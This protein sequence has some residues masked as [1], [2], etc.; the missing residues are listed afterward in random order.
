VAKEAAAQQ[1][2][3]ASREKLRAAKEKYDAERH[4]AAELRNEHYLQSHTAAGVTLLDPTGAPPHAPM[5]PLL[6]RALCL[7]PVQLAQRGAAAARSGRP[8]GQP[9]GSAA[10]ALGPAARRYAGPV[11]GAGC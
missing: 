8:R 6:R 7:R 11:M 4:R 2:A 10:S 3:A 5:P 9:G 1:R